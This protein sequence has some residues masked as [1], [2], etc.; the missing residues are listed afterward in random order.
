MIVN[1]G[2]IIMSGNKF[3]NSRK[4]LVANMIL[5]SIIFGFALGILSFSC[6][7][8]IAT[9]DQ[10][11]A[12]GNLEGLTALESIQYSFRQVAGS[13]LPVVVEIFTI[14]IVEQT[15][16]ENPFEFF[17]NGPEDPDSENDTQQYRKSGLG[18]GVIV[19]KEGNKIY[20]LTN[21]HVVGEADEISVVLY[22][23]DEEF[24][25]Q[26]IG[27]DERT[28]LALISFETSVDVPVAILGNSD[29]L[30][31]GDWVLAIGNPF[32]FESTVTAGIVSAL[33]REGG[34]GGNISAF[35]QTDAA[36][37]PGNSGGALVNIKG[38]VIGINTWIASTTGTSVG[39][40]FAIPINS[41]K[42][43][44]EEFIELGKI[45]YAW[46]GISM[47][48]PE[49]LKRMK[50]DMQLVEMDGAF[51]KNVFN[52]SP[53]YEG[54]ILPGDFI[55]K[56][57]GTDIND[58]L[59]LTRYLGSLDPGLAAEFDIIRA[60]EEIHL[61]IILAVRE[62]EKEIAAQNQN[63]WP[64]F[65][66]LPMADD[67]KEMLGINL[68]NGIFVNGVYEDTPAGIAGLE[69][70]DII[71]KINNQNINNMMDFY[72]ILNDKKNRNLDLTIIRNGVELE[73]K[74]IR[75]E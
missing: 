62:E 13:V 56:L 33:E 57:N 25:A 67:I 1:I 51:V 71:T 11:Y 64:G 36:I 3:L 35:I 52:G 66:V 44:I 8:K 72:T 29:E 69:Y 23:D 58:Y 55:I 9:E 60:G 10:V 42:Q 48:V 45:E 54:G 39:Y 16:P 14:D 41:A 15:N 61:S 12:Y 75:L 74:L 22:E 68:D 26:L 70:Q 38:E 24:E 73:I 59:H 18:S 20:V 6:S 5:V 27:S 4:V 21:Y 49:E 53:A 17:F 50:E 40:G 65:A 43:A 2:D 32:G 46:L 19:K 37:N 28:D 34:P 63:L 47:A 7:T 31:V 30:F